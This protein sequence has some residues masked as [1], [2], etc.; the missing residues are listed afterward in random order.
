[1]TRT[2]AMAFSAMFCAIIAIL[3]QIAIPMPSG[4]P[5]TLQ[6]FAIALTGFLLGWKRGSF[7]VLLYILLG[8]IG[9]PVFSSLRSG[10]YTLLGL[11]GGFIF[12]FIPFV[13]LSG[14]G[15]NFKKK[16]LALVFC[17]LGLIICHLMGSLQ[18]MII[19]QISF[20][21]SLLTV[22]FPYLLKD[23]VSCILAYGLYLH[24]KKI[25]ALLPLEES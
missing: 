2:K 22:S 23:L 18:F 8:L 1:M 25:R 16:Y 20:Y 19:S 10:I 9:V 6:T 3:S 21:K 5:I 11:T 15:R 12:G 17:F 7:S 14:L 13:L 24:L 4:I